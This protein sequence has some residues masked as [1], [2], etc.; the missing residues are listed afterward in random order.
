MDDFN[1]KKKELLQP[2]LFEAGAAL[3]DCQSFEFGIALLLYHFS[4]LGTEGLKP[5]D[6]ILVLE[7]NSKKTAGQLIKM[8]RDHLKISDGIENALSEALLARNTIIHRF[9]IDNIEEFITE[10][11]REQLIKQLRIL[12]RKVQNGDKALRPFITTLSG[13]LDGV[14][15]ETIQSEA[16]NIFLNKRCDA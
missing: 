5:N 4:R 16:K 1:I 3:L 8:L 14:D 2:L 10:E 9:L 13:A 11:S 12:R 15:F 6:I 7:N